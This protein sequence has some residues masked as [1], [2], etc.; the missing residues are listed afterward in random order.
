[1]LSIFVRHTS[2]CLQGDGTAKNPGL[3][4]K[5]LSPAELRTYRRCQCPKYFTGTYDGR[6]Y[7][8]TSC[9]ACTWEAAE[10]AVARVR[11]L[12][13]LNIT[14]AQA[15]P[16]APGPPRIE[17]PR[18]TLLVDAVRSWVTECRT[19]GLRGMRMWEH[20][21]EILLLRAKQ[22]HV[23][24]VEGITPLFINEW[25]A[26]WANEQSP[27][28]KTPGLMPNTRKSRLRRLSHFLNHCVRMQYIKETPM[29]LIKPAGR[30]KQKRVAG[31]AQRQDEGIATLPIDER[32]D[33]NYRRIIAYLPEFFAPKRIDGQVISRRAALG[34]RPD[35]FGA[36]LQLM[37][38]TGLRVSDAILFEVDAVYDTGHGWG[39]YTT[40]QYKT[41]GNVTVVIEPWLLTKLRC[42]P[43]I[44]A[45]YLFWDGH[46]AI[47]RYE[48]T[49]V[50]AYLRE[51][52]T[53][54]GIEKLHAHRFR[55]SFAVNKLNEG[56][57]I[58][59]VSKALGHKSVAITEM[60]YSPWVRS[61]EEALI[62]TWITTPIKLPANVMEPSQ[63]RPN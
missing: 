38:T 58:Q 36:L 27:R 5:K 1:M 39:S 46:R 29:R 4:S 32:G 50:G 14:P 17:T 6:W 44:A 9:D 45:R 3:A 20:L 11:S 47:D 37:Y 23:A 59:D 26:A 49:Q 28:K 33:A 16:P 42:L 57:K 8:R 2:K 56:W 60:Y 15:A 40:T 52:G 63:T 19:D 25:R 48:C 10:R 41:G 43:Y 55:D 12:Q 62:H 35:N 51:I 7:P 13:D 24:T 31:S 54:L 53:K 22:K 61:R 30:R 21:G 18:A 34:S